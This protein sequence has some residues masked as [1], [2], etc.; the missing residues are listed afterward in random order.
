[1]TEVTLEFI[2][3]QLEGIQA[4][5]DAMQPRI[6]GIPLFAR[7]LEVLQRDVQRLTDETRVA[8]AIAQRGTNTMPELL[9]ELRA[10]HQWMIG[11]GNRVR[12]LEDTDGDTR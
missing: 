4:R 10:I 2:G 12:R 1:M 11:F 5:L 7:A 8:T 9:E 6:D 3:H